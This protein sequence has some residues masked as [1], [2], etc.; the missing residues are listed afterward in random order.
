MSVHPGQPAGR[1]WMSFQQ[2]GCRCVVPDV[3]DEIFRGWLP[4]VLRRFFTSGAR[5][6]RRIR[7]VDSCGDVFSD[8]GANPGASTN[9]PNKTGFLAQFSR[10]L[11]D[12]STTVGAVEQPNGCVER[13][14]A[15][16]HVPLRR[17]EAGDRRTPESPAPVRPASLGASRT[18]DAVDALHSLEPP[19]VV[20]PS[21]R[22]H[23]RCLA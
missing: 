16:V 10:R 6:Q 2:A 7:I 5:F 14:R 3:G 13:R 21:E 17:P 4:A 20:L 22:A 1:D 9:F 19:P 12:S 11:H 23:R 18:C 8:P 15:Q